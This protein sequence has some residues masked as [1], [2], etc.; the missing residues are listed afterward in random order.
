MRG[1]RASDR[2]NRWIPDKSFGSH[3][4]EARGDRASRRFLIAS[5]NRRAFFERSAS[6]VSH[7]A[8][9]RRESG[10]GGGSFSGL[11][12]GFRLPEEARSAQRR[13]LDADR[14]L[15][16]ASPRSASCA[17]PWRHVHARRGHRHGWVGGGD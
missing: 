9:R 15:K 7:R 10:V 8:L 2:F 6:D 16:A 11:R 13:K 17:Y 12:F 4:P 14:S 3:H 1:C 5:C